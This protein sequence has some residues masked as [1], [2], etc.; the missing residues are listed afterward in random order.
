MSKNKNKTGKQASLNEMGFQTFD[1]GEQVPFLNEAPQAIGIG[2]IRN[3]LGHLVVDDL[4]GLL[5]ELSPLNIIDALNDM[6]N[7]YLSAGDDIGSREIMMAA[8]EIANKHMPEKRLEI[9]EDIIYS[10]IALQ[11]WES[12]TRFSEAGIAVTISRHIEGEDNNSKLE[13]LSPDEFDNLVLFM[14]HLTTSKIMHFKLDEAQ[15]HISFLEETLEVEPLFINQYW[16]LL[17][18]KQAERKAI[19]SGDSFPVYPDVSIGYS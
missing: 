18:N 16:A 7:Q 10:C 2:L 9:I 12:V 11:D 15:D 3:E 17:Y 8:L 14:L 5:E 13:D 1:P 4:D 6:A 19:E